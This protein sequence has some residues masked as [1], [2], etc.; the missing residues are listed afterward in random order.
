MQHDARPSRVAGESPGRSTREDCFAD[1]VVIDFPALQPI[2]ERMRLAFLDGCEPG[3][4]SLLAEVCLTAAQ[5]RRGSRVAVA[6]PVRRVCQACGG[7]GEVWNEPC[8]RCAGNGTGMAH[9]RVEVDV[10]SGVHD[11]ECLSISLAA[12]PDAPATRVRLRV[13][14]S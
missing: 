13:S 12:A 8:A 14:V 11:G 5:A 3:E 1:D 10:P 7:R 2:V 4:G 9:H 6:V